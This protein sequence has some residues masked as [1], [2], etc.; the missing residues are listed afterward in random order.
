M[1]NNVLYL[2]FNKVRKFPGLCS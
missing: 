2:Y 1:K